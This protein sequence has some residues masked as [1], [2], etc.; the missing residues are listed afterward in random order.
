MLYL[1]GLGWHLAVVATRS[2]DAVSARWLPAMSDWFALGI[3]LAVV[4]SSAEVSAA[5]A[6][7]RR[8]ADRFADAV[9]AGAFLAFVVVCNIGLPVDGTSGTV[10]EDVARQVLFGLVAALLVAPAALGTTHRG[11]AMRVLDCRPAVLLGTISYGVFLWHYEWIAQVQT[12]GGFDWF[13]DAR[14]LTVFVLVLGL[15]LVTATASWLL[16]ERPLLRRKD[17]VGRSAPT[18]TAPPVPAP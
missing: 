9:V 13:R 8:V 12:W 11:F 16:V 7:V 1:F 10:R 18:P 3:L 2:P 17:R 4:R 14:T 5:A 15:T 6:S